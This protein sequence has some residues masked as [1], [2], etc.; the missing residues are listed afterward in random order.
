MECLFHCYRPVALPAE[1]GTTINEQ[2]TFFSFSG[3]QDSYFGPMLPVSA[4]AGLTGDEAETFKVS[5]IV[6]ITVC[7]SGLT[8]IYNL[9]G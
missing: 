9:S 1:D 8:L 6:C 7:C 4:V 3:A 2:N 5:S